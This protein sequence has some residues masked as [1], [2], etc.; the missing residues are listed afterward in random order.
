MKCPN[1]SHVSE[2]AL[3]KCAQCGEVYDRAALERLEHL[4]RERQARTPRAVAAVY[5]QV[6][7]ENGIGADLV[8]KFL[9]NGG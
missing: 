4:V 5:A 2:T 7:R 3:L 6:I 9:S 8:N 1:C